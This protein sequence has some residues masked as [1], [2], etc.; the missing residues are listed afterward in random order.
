[1]AESKKFKTCTIDGYTDFIF[2]NQ[3][4]NVY[5]AER[6]DKA[7]RDI[8]ESYNK[9]EEVIAKA[10]ERE[11]FFLPHLSCHSLRHTFCTRLCERDVNIKVIQTVMGHANIK[12]TMD[13][14]AEVSEEKKMREIEAMADELDVF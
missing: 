5:T 3:N 8:I 6:L 7:L 2:T 14:Y 10:E 4:G 1:M 13:I 11:P 9:Q 12:I